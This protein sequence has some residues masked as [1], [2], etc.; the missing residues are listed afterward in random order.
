MGVIDNIQSLITAAN[1][2]T[3]KTDADMTA[4]TKSLIAGYGGGGGDIYDYATTPVTTTLE[5]MFAGAVFP[6]GFEATLNLSIL[7]PAAV[8]T[9]VS[10]L[11]S[12]AKNLKSIKFKRKPEEPEIKIDA[13]Y[14]FFN[15]FALKMVDISQANFIF[16][17][18]YDT[19]SGCFNLEEIKGAIKLA[20]DANVG[21]GMFNRAPNLKEVRFAPNSILKTFRLNASPKLSA[22]SI[23]SIIGGLSDLSSTAPQTLTLHP[24]VKGILTPKQLNTIS[25]K[26]WT[27]A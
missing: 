20:P 4:A 26:N 14:M 21:G 22:E 9:S 11:F 23:Q 25:S 24:D 6:E 16:S 2:A 13:H 8:K 27:L 5:K 18:C 19:F 17:T 10:S 12:A 3:G 15:I 7:R 1:S